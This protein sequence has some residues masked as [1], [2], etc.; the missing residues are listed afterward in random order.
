MIDALAVYLQQKPVIE[1]KLQNYFDGESN[2]RLA[3]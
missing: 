3:Y 1:N 2:S